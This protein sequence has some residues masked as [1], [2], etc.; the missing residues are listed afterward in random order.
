[1]KRT[2]IGGPWRAWLVMLAVL[3]AF[4]LGAALVTAPAQ[5]DTELGVEEDEP[6][7]TDDDLFGEEP[8]AVDEGESDI[9]Q[10]GADEPGLDITGL[11]DEGDRE[12]DTETGGEVAGL[13]TVEE[14]GAEKEGDVRAGRMSFLAMLN[15]GGPL[16]YVL[17]FIEI[18]VLALVLESC[19]NVN[20]LKVLP[21]GFVEE[22]GKDF[23][24]NDVDAVVQ[25]C[26]DNPGMLSNVLHAGL[27]APAKTD[28]DVKEAIELAG[29]HEGESFMS[30]VGYLSIF[31]T[32]A[33]MVGLLGTVIGMILAFRSVAL[34]AAIGKPEA[35]ATG[36]FQALFTTAFG[37]IIGI[38]AMFMKWRSQPSNTGVPRG[39]LVPQR[40]ALLV[41]EAL[42]N[43]FVGIMPIVGFILGPFAIAKAV[44][45]KAELRDAGG[46]P[47][48]AYAAEPWKATMALLLGVVDIVIWPVAAAVAVI[49]T[50]A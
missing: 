42:S 17:L 16:M 8:G 4:G 19:F 47:G 9:E 1:M 7:I 32:I 37:L 24:K 22:I 38:P 46:N 41:D 3:V 26:E 10:P 14:A 30:H 11:G 35:L 45:I 13:G 21:A 43:A 6:G 25:K 20:A 36:I 39:G 18:V 15:Q 48:G 5:T 34:E 50:S 27:T 49:V 33:P 29:E 28:A 40:L 44:R 31:G 12:G 23:G 2:I